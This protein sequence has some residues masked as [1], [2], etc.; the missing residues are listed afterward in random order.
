MAV[1]EKVWNVVVEE[2]TYKVTLAKNKISVNGS[3]P[4]KFTKLQKAVGEGKGSNYIVPLGNQNAILRVSNLGLVALT[5]DGK[6]CLTGEAYEPP[7]TPWWIWI[8]VVLH[9]LGF[10]FLIGGAIGGAIQ[11]GVICVMLA[12][13]SDNK[14]ETAYKVGVC[15]AILAISLLVQFG[16]AYLIV[17]ALM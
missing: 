10:F 4:V 14:K 15:T 16:L 17:R 9:A 7:K 13:A 12:I 11:G 1:K 8:H 6:D 5:L 2:V 3:E